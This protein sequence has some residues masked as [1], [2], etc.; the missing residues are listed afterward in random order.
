MTALIFRRRMGSATTNNGQLAAH[1]GARWLR[2]SGWARRN[3]RL[4][5]SVPQTAIYGT[6]YGQYRG[7]GAGEARLMHAARCYDNNAGCAHCAR[8]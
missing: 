5:C 8:T 1:F 6:A 2:G 4:P 3:W 7:D